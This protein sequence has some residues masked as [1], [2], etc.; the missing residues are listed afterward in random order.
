MIDAGTVEPFAGELAGAV[1]AGATRLLVDMTRV[2]EVTAAG[3]NALLGVRQRLG[4]SGAL[5]LVL[6][7]A[8]RASFELLGLDRRFLVARDRTEAARL[9]GLTGAG[10]P[11]SGAPVPRAHAA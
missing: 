6:P 11:E 2:D 1:R 7:A 5:A 4:A 10:T 8:I 9:L 3:M